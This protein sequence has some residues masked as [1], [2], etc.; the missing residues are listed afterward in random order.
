MAGDASKLRLPKK[1]NTAAAAVTFELA[2]PA[3]PEELTLPM[4]ESIN[5]DGFV[6]P[7]VPAPP[8]NLLARVSCACACPKLLTRRGAGA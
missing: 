7:A 1:S 3:N 4:P 6:E 2:V 8:Q 5:A